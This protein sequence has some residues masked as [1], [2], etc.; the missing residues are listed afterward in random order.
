MTG[1]VRKS[2]FTGWGDNAIPTDSTF[3]FVYRGANYKITYQDLIDN[4]GVSGSIE[5]E[6]DPIGRLYIEH[7]PTQHRVIDITI[8]PHLRGQ[9]LGGAIMRDVMDE[10]AKA[11]KA[12]SINVETNNVAMHL[13]NRLG[14]KVIEKGDVYDLMRWE[15]A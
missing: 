14:F 15:R 4:L 10:A 5:Q 8:L 2:R 3:D 9:G 6:G 13:Y 7:W 12:V 11:G 1:T